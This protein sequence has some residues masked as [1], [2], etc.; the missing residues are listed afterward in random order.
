[1]M[2]SHTRDGIVLASVCVAVF[3]A[4]QFPTVPGGDSGELIVAAC[5]LGIPHPPGYPLHTM[6]GH[7]ALQALPFGTPAARVGFVSVLC[8]AGAAALLSATVAHLLRAVLTDSA[9]GDSMHAARAASVAGAG[10]HTFSPLVWTY[11]TQA[12]VFALN[13]LFA[14][15]LVF[16]TAL[17][18]VPPPAALAE[19][20]P[21]ANMGPRSATSIDPD[22]ITEPVGVARMA[23]QPEDTGTRP[24]AEAPTKPESGQSQQGVDAA[25]GRTT[26]AA[27]VQTRPA[28]WI[29]YAGAGLIGLG[30]TN[31]HTL[32]LLALPLSF[33]ILFLGRSKLL[34]PGALLSLIG[35]GL[36]GLTPYLYLVVVGD[37]PQRG[38]WGDPASLVGLA[39]HVL[40]KEYGTFKL[41]SGTEGQ[42]QGL[43]S[44]T[45]GTW[46]YIQDL[47]RQ[48]LVIG[49]LWVVIG[50][51]RLVRAPATR[52]LA[53]TLI[54][55]WV[56]YTLA[57]H[58]LA[59]LPLE[60]NRHRQ[61]FR[62]VH[63]RFWLQPNT[64]LAVFLG[65]G[66]EPLIRRGAQMLEVAR[67]RCAVQTQPAGE[68]GSQTCSSRGTA[69]WAL[70]WAVVGVQVALHYAECDKSRQWAVWDAGFATL[71]SVPQG[72]LLLIKGDLNTNAVRY[73]MEC[74]GARPD[75]QQLDLSHVSYA[76]FNRRHPRVWHS[77]VTLPGRRFTRLHRNPPKGAY[78]LRHL[79]ATNARR[80]P[81]VITPGL[82]GLD[83]DIFQNFSLWPSGSVYRIYPRDAPPR[84]RPW[85][86][87]NALRL[88]VLDSGCIR[89][90]T[91][92]GTWEAMAARD[93][94][95][96]HAQVA[97]H[98]LA[99]SPQ[100]PSFAACSPASASTS[101]L[102]LQSLAA[103]EARTRCRLQVRGDT[104]PRDTAEAGGIG[105]CGTVEGWQ[106]GEGDQCN[107]AFLDTCHGIVNGDGPLVRLE[108]LRCAAQALLCVASVMQLPPPLVWKNA[109]AA[110]EQIQRV[111][112]DF[113]GK[114]GV[115][116]EAE[117][118]LEAT[119]MR[120][121]HR[122]ATSV[123]CV[124]S[125][126]SH[127]TAANTG[128]ESASGQE[129]IS[130]RAEASG[131]P[132]L[133]GIVAVLASRGMS[134]TC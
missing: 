39:V 72:A 80:F 32:V 63:A 24:V 60:H 34:H 69:S 45:T 108:W 102:C 31:Q 50:M 88:P 25:A 73:L 133:A 74:E 51:F 83:P 47:P 53:L 52:A 23:R 10:I 9:D 91:D 14:A 128:P 33:C 79:L 119:K 30:L 3:A 70:A 96:A 123:L 124:N 17:Y 84:L 12:E 11:S 98:M 59:N 48:L 77:N 13:N 27:A 106:V 56:G 4:T 120:A 104:E 86:R 129:A 78:R 62:A 125:A 132:E 35:C 103:D 1:M 36:L 118:D 5:S 58:S 71:L 81:I 111:R 76:W 26:P 75:V 85:L 109:A 18:L 134:V 95:I 93:S 105:L 57:F 29:P 15:A 8:S 37:T 44:L 67:C 6:L 68:A 61:L 126:S 107:I 117:A 65:A 46:L 20:A 130:A 38:A 89:G 66:V 82:E 115:E 92:S 40:R 114:E 41:F 100:H 112:A 113:V 121:L 116:P 19:A 87:D 43:A 97:S 64:L 28:S 110:L 131:D 101:A 49:P 22:E 21:V 2:H 16:L 127:A 42:P 99:V 55:S 122:Y 54:A 90:H 94:A 7:L